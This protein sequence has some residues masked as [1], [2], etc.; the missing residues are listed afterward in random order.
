MYF[1]NKVSSILQQLQVDSPH[2]TG[3]VLLSEDGLPIVSQL[4]SDL[5][6]ES[7]AGMNS[8]LHNIGVNSSNELK[9]GEIEQLMIR[10]EHGYMVVSSV[11]N[12]TMLLVVTD[13]KVVLGSVFHFMKK[14]VSKISKIM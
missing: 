13:E 11:I 6:A 10:A 8:V 3:A 4:P 5:E 7:V 12:G 9:I 1:E 2:V 14:A